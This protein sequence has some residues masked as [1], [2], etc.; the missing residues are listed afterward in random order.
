M[1]DAVK[2]PRWVKV[3]NRRGIYY[4]EGANG[5]RA[6][7]VTYTDSEGRRRWQRMQGGLTDAEAALEETRQRLRRGERVAPTRLRSRRSPRHG[8]P[9]SRN[10]APPRGSVTYGR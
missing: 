5:R 6:Y 1:Q 9:H 7:E 3:K 8:S 2:R 10:F 4:R